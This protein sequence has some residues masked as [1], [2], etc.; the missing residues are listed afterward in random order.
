MA[1]A[2]GLRKLLNSNLLH[3][4]RKIQRL[5]TSKS[6]NTLQRFCRCASTFSFVP[7]SPSPLDGKPPIAKNLLIS[8]KFNVISLMNELSFKFSSNIPRKLVFSEDSL[9][10]L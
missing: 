9:R 10:K 8:F 4:S 2:R 7:D 5:G 6:S 1:G 3:F